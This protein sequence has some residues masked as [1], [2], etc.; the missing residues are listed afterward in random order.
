[1]R[2]PLAVTIWRP[3]VPPVVK[4]AA[5]MAAGTVGQYVVRRVLT[6]MITGARK[7]PARALRKAGDGMFDEAQIITETVMMRRVRIRRQA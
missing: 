2:R 5:V 4:G 1:M 6:N 3:H 7:K